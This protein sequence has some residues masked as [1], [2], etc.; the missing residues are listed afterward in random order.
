[1]SLLF[2]DTSALAKRYLVETGTAWIVG[3]SQ[4]AAGNV[5]I[6]ADLATVEMASLLARRVREG[7]LAAGDARILLTSCLRHAE[8]EYLSVPQDN[9][10]LV[11]ARTLVDRYPLRTLDAIHL[12]SAQRS[13]AILN[14]ATSFVSSDRNLLAA[15]T[16]E[17][18]STDDPLAHP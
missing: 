15:A 3:V 7:T 11:Q 13:G 17:G 14:E 8:R 18:M 4:P 12:A 10:V 1:L 16:A 2:F 5:I 6:I 9:H